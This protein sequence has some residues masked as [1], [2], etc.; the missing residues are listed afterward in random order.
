MTDSLCLNLFLIKVNH[1]RGLKS[2]VVPQ[3]VLY[4]GTVRCLPLP[5]GPQRHSYSIEEESPH[6]QLGFFLFPAL[7]FATFSTSLLAF[8]YRR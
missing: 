6:S 1:V 5:A 7:D 2:H 8:Y 4:E 3:G